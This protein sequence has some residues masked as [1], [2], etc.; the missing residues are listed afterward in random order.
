MDSKMGA[1]FNM[2]VVVVLF[3]VIVAALGTVLFP[4]VMEKIQHIVISKLDSALNTGN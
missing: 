3:V 2:V 1:L 4:E